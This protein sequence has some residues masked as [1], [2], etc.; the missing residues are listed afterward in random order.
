MRMQI[1][2]AFL[3][4]VGAMLI[5]LIGLRA[6]VRLVLPASIIMFLVSWAILEIWVVLRRKLQGRHEPDMLERTKKR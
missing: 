4:T 5:V 6:P 1:V 3:F 2:E